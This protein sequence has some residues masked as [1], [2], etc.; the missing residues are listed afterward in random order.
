MAEAR[1]PEPRVG[2]VWVSTALPGLRY[3]IIDTV[4]G[5]A[6]AVRI[7]RRGGGNPLFLWSDDLTPDRWRRVTPGPE[8]S[9]EEEGSGG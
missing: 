4:P 2:D 3:R 9:E 8:R 5:L 7:G 1:N 6:R